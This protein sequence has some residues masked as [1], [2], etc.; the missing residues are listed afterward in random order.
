MNYSNTYTIQFAGLPEGFHNYEFDVKVDFFRTYYEKN[1]LLDAKLKVT[2]NAEKSAY[3]LK[4]YLHCTGWIMVSCDRCLEPCK[5]DIKSSNVLVFSSI[6]VNEIALRDCGDIEYFEVS[7]HQE[8]ITLDNHIYDFV[9][10]SLPMRRVH[11]DF[12]LDQT[13][14]NKDI[15]KLI[16]TNQSHQYTDPR[17]AVLEKLKHEQS[18]N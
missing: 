2:I 17:W 16:S 10:L 4:V 11:D 12:D 7:E 18:K 8:F 15:I 3:M 9:M 5:F 14:C 6:P 1:E 13:H